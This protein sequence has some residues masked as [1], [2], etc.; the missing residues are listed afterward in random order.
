VGM[1]LT[2]VPTECDLHDVVGEAIDELR[3]A[4]P[5]RD[6]QH[7]HTGD[8]RCAADVTRIVQLVGNLVSNAVSYGRA[9][10]PITLTTDGTRGDVLT[11]AVHN[12]GQAI[13]PALLPILFEPMTRGSQ[14]NNKR[15]VGL[16][17]F[18][19]REIA[20]AHGGAMAVRSSEPEGTT[21]T[22]TLPRGAH[23]ARN[24]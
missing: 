23:F 22:L 8:G 21:F 11:L 3:L 10:T 9:E 20:K 24:G 12:D 2:C 6:L 19:V 5:G 15:S 16:G 1:G 14:A 4:Y 17:L 7:V 18:I 13:P